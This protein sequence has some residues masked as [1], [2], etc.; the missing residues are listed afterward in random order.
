MA[1]TSTPK[2]T[3][4]ARSTRRPKVTTPTTSQ[5]RR[6]RKAKSPIAFTASLGIQGWGA[7]DA[8]L[9]AAL[10]LEAPVLLVGAHGT[11]KT[12]VAERV[13]NALDQQFRHY[14]ASL[15]N[16]DDLV[17][18]PVPDDNGGL[19]YLGAEG[20]VWDAEFVFLDEINRCRPDLQNKLF[21]LVHERRIAGEDLTALH[22]RWAAINPPGLLG[23]ADSHYLGVEELDEALIDRF[24]FIVP[25]PNW[26]E[27][28]RDDRI[29]LVRSGAEVPAPRPDEALPVDLIAQTSAALE[30]IDATSGDRIAD[31][32]VTLVDELAK[33]GVLLSPRRARLLLRAIC[34]VHAARIILEGDKSD[35]VKSAEIALVHALPSRATSTP[36]TYSQVMAAHRQAWELSDLEQGAL[37]RELL[38]EPDPVRRVWIANQRGA[39]DQ[40]LA[41]LITAAFAAAPSKADQYSLAAVFTRAFAE[42][43]LTPAAWSPLTELAQ[44]VLVPRDEVHRVLPGTELGTV[45]E[46]KAFIAQNEVDDLDRAFLY[47]IDTDWFALVSDWRDVF[48]RFREQR[49]LFGVN[50]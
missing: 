33:G 29:A 39:D 4:S 5:P 48:A 20:A 24:W 44:T 34:A 9:L 15:L 46:I 45:R 36:P 38:E 17:G 49:E 6:S 10:A 21:P 12:L 3:R 41:R 1:A 37:Q 28:G 43:D 13:A 26:S 40:M 11:A 19:N 7:V 18:I 22:H 27:I 35:L 30:A 8:I 42:R 32:V 14:N 50:P 16:Y 31:Y 2:S 25:V 23:D 47:G